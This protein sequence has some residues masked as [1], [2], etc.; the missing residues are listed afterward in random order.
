MLCFVCRVLVRLSETVFRL[1]CGC[2][3]RSKITYIDLPDVIEAGNLFVIHFFPFDWV[4][5]PIP[6]LGR[7]PRVD[8]WTAI[9]CESCDE[10]RDD[11]VV[12]GMFS[13]KIY[14]LFWFLYMCW[15]KV[16]GCPRNEVKLWKLNFSNIQRT[17]LLTA[18]YLSGASLKVLFY[19]P[20]FL[21]A[22]YIFLLT[23]WMVLKHISFDHLQTH[24]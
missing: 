22:Y 24:S 9:L 1:Y 4:V 2:S 8:T 17:R 20:T 6:N 15:W 23:Y 18:K 13:Y 21:Y 19:F 5:R 12:D 7:Y 3:V 14:K 11:I 10:P 16:K